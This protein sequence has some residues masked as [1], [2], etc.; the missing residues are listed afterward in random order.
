MTKVRLTYGLALLGFAGVVATILIWNLAF[1]PAS[2][3][4]LYVP[5]GFLLVPLAFPLL[6]LVKGRPYTHAWSTFMAIYY[7]VVGTW[8]AAGGE[9]R[10]YGTAIGL[11]SVLWFVGSMFFTRA[12]SRALRNPS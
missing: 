7:F 1:R 11:F 2:E 12:K 9:T 8:I 3:I 4:P 6:G 5:L 10:W